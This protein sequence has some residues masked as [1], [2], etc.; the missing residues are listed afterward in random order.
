MVAV[1][2]VAEWI[3]RQLFTLQLA[4][5]VKVLFASAAALERVTLDV[6][7]MV[8][9]CLPLLPSSTAYWV[10]S[11]AAAAL[12]LE[13]ARDRPRVVRLPTE[14]AEAAH[15]LLRRAVFS[16]VTSVGGALPFSAVSA[17]DGMPRDLVEDVFSC[18]ER[19]YG[20]TPA[21]W[22]AYGAQVVETLRATDKV[23]YLDGGVITDTDLLRRLLDTF[24]GVRFLVA[25]R[26][27]AAVAEDS[28]LDLRP[29]IDPVDEGIAMGLLRDV[30][31]KV[32]VPIVTARGT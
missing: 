5:L 29:P 24:A 27:A 26:A 11:D 6:F 15:L 1:P 10:P 20:V 23:L 12:R 22:P 14:R 16:E 32:G 19:R 7:Q 25:S 18:L 28:V 21:T 13:W 9:C 8:A 31:D 3:A 30:E 2:D 17:A 4:Q